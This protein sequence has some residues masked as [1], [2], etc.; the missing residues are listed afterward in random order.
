MRRHPVALPLLMTM[1]LA[2]LAAGCVRPPEPRVLSRRPARSGELYLLRR[3]VVA[4]VRDESGVGSGV[5]EALGEILTTYLVN[6]RM[7]SVFERAQLEQVLAEQSL[8][9]DGLTTPET[10][11]RVGSLVGAQAVVLATLTTFGEQQRSF[12]GVD[13][14][15]GF[16]LD[17]H[18]VEV[19]LD[20][21][22][23]D[24]VNGRIVF[25]HNAVGQQRAFGGA[26]A[27]ED[28][29][30][31]RELRDDDSLI[32][33]A[34]REVV[35]AVI[36]AIV[37]KL[38]DLPWTGAV[39]KADGDKIYLNAGEEV[40]VEPGLRFDVFAA[41][42]ELIDPDTG[43]TLG[44]DENRRGTVEVVEVH[45]RYSI[46]RAVSG[47]GFQTGDILRETPPEEDAPPPTS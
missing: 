29:V 6:T 18:A 12:G 40:G 15:G 42:E 46:G 21:R 13:E 4:P 10:A 23:V 34:A 44:R 35:E 22:I 43:L 31:S 16:R 24:A 14:D 25:A 47:T 30:L 9:L 2:L 3:I 5:S 45:G 17:V 28:L 19:G 39:V 1:I 41:G 32:S 37:V 7:F 8:G 26:L 33:K 11:A 36:E 27:G 20:L 38:D